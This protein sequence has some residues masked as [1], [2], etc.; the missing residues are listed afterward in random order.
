MLPI[1]LMSVAA[2]A[3]SGKSL[4]PAQQAVAPQA[5]QCKKLAA[6][7]RRLAAALAKET[8]E[9]RALPITDDGPE[10]MIGNFSTSFSPRYFTDAETTRLQKQRRKVTKAMKANHC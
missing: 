2:C 3:G 4:Q 9:H 10:V 8:A 5:G 7:D 1:I 6:E